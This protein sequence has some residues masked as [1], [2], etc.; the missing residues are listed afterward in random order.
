MIYIYIYREREGEGEEGR[1][2]EREGYYRGITSRQEKKKKK[3]PALTWKG[4]DNKKQF[5][6]S[7]VFFSRF[8]C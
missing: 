2:G 7:P 6:V 4:D 5:R 3:G 8:C 1:E